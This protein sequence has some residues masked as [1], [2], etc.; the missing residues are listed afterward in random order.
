MKLQLFK[1]TYGVLMVLAMAGLFM[2]LRAQ[3]GSTFALMLW[4]I[5]ILLAAVGL[6]ATRNDW[7]ATGA[8]GL[9]LLSTLYLRQGVVSH[10][11]PSG[12]YTLVAAYYV[13]LAAGLGYNLFRG[14]GGKASTR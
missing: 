3:R 11:E 6:V 13:L 5:L 2:M 9:G 12:R 14:R 8:A 10:G 7:F 4:L 1:G